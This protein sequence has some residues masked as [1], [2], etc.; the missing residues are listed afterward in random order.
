MTGPVC[1]LRVVP[2]SPASVSVMTTRG[3]R[4]SR[5]GSRTSFARD[6]PRACCECC[7]TADDGGCGKG[8]ARI[9][10][11]FHLIYYR[12][13]CNSIFK[14]KLN[15]CTNPGV[16]IQVDP[17]GLLS[18]FLEITHQSCSYQLNEPKAAGGHVVP[19]N[20]IILFLR[21]RSMTR[22]MLI[23]CSMVTVML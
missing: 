15:P 10:F 9:S 6:L 17:T 11:Q 14:L 12:Q 8:P 19:V 18:S 20:Q 1:E 16:F 7:R 23:Q 21:G 4:P 22:S 13:R 5:R 3:S 2:S